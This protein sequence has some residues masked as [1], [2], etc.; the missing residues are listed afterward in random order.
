MWYIKYYIL[1]LDCITYNQLVNILIAYITIYCIIIYLYYNIKNH[2][3]IF[4]GII[5]SYI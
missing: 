4:F 5:H 1:Y 2:R 3:L